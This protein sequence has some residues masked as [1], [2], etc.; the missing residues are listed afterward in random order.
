M[1]QPIFWKAELRNASHFML[2]AHSMRRSRTKVSSQ[3]PKLEQH[4]LGRGHQPAAVLW[5]AGQGLGVDQAQQAARKTQVHDFT[6][7]WGLHYFT[8][9]DIQEDSERATW[10][11]IKTAL[12]P[13]WHL[14]GLLWRHPWVPRVVQHLH[15]V[16]R[17]GQN[18]PRLNNVKHLQLNSTAVV[19]SDFK[20]TMNLGG[21]ETTRKVVSDMYATQCSVQS[22]P[23]AGPSE[24]CKVDNN[25]A[26]HA[27]QLIGPTTQETTSPILVMTASEPGMAAVEPSMSMYETVLMESSYWTNGMACVDSPT[28]KALRGIGV[29]RP[30]LMMAP[31]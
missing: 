5:R 8:N 7:H 19:M 25:T 24:N 28:W 11:A 18:G 4:G 23:V 21:S 29:R 1:L 16:W 12:R 30:Y 15:Q 20:K 10:S 2:M 22:R 3:S 27:I 26:A 9:L 13:R 17:P 6:F 14:L 31:P